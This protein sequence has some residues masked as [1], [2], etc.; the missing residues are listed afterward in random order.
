V[1][2][3]RFV[4]NL[5]S[6]TLPSVFNPWAEL[7]PV[8]DLK[9]AVE[10]RR[11]NLTLALEKALQVGVQSVVIGRDLG[12]RGGRRTGL[13]LTDEPHL[14]AFSEMYGGLSIRRATMG[15]IVAERTA[16]MFWEIVSR[17]PAPV[18]TWNVFPYH[19]HEPGK[20]HSNRCHT[21]SER[22][23]CRFA[24]VDLLE[25][26]QPQLIIAVGNDAATGL[27]DLGLDAVK[28]RHPS[29][30]GKSDFVA[31]MLALHPGLCSA[32]GG[33]AQPALL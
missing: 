33:A 23:Q 27:A 14:G 18:F 24:L 7:C 20:P 4:E 3:E 8:A 30:G 15:P 26:L 22:R 19:P 31:G 1:T 25:L 17:L 11:A 28:V 2:P 9:N 5:A 13:A 12:Y 16:A 21:R 29:Y 10:I 6:G 32:P